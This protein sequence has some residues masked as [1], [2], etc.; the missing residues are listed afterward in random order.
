MLYIM[1]IPANKGLKHV[2]VNINIFLNIDITTEMYFPWVS[3]A[4][5][6]LI[7]TQKI[8]VERK[9]PQPGHGIC[10]GVLTKWHMF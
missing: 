2:A 4:W 7:E 8:S 1:Y 10:N 6:N 5:I 9:T 3:C